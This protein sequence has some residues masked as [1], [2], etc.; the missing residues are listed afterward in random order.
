MS[1]KMRAKCELKITQLY[2]NYVRIYTDAS[3]EK[4]GRML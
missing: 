2:K 4:N 1:E 3:R